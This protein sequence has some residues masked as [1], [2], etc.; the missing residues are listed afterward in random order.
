MFVCITTYLREFDLTEPVVSDHWAYQDRA[1]S[2]GRL[3]CSGPQPQGGGG[4]AI[5]RGDDEDEAR[6]LL[7]NDPFVAGGVVTYQLIPFRTTRG[8]HPDLIERPS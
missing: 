4:I 1:F 7:D 2:E 6:R 5:V 8:A 3:V